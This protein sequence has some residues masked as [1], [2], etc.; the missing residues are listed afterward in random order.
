QTQPLQASNHRSG[1]IAVL[2]VGGMDIQHPQQAQRVYGEMAF[3]PFDLLTGVITDSF[4]RFLGPP[5]SVVLT[6]WLSTITAEG[7]GSL[8]ACSRT[9]PR[10]VSC[11]LSSVPSSRH[12]RK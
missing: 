10:R 3:A 6:V 5:F 8:P 7:V 2:D 12:C 11:T 1:G 4:V 9:C